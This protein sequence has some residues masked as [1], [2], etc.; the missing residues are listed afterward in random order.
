MKRRPRGTGSI[1]K[2]G[3]GWAIRYGP[4]GATTSESGFPSRLAAENRLAQ[5]RLDAARPPTAPA[6]PNP[7]RERFKRHSACSTFKT[8]RLDGGCEVCG[9]SPPEPCTARALH[10]HHV[11]PVAH[12][13]DDSDRNLLLVCPNHHAVAHAL[14]RVYDS[15]LLATREDVIDALR[16]VD[17]RMAGATGRAASTASE[18]F[19][20][21]DFL[22]A[23]SQPAR[24]R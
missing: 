16:R 3:G 18:V 15:T 9:W 13:G 11:V 4:R 10:V 22:G 19:G 17:S 14:R 7:A 6:P 24:P 8:A 21:A 20:G 23:A 12:G 5:I 1:I 2:Q